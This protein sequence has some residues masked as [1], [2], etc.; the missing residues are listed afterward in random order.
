MYA[1][2]LNVA[3]P[4]RKLSIVEQSLPG[5][6]EPDEDE[7]ERRGLPDAWVY[8][9]DGWSLL[10]ESKIESKLGGNQLDRHYKTAIRRGFSDVTVLAI[11]VDRPARKHKNVLYKTWSEIYIWLKKRATNSQWASHAA[12]YLEV[13]ESRFSEDGYLKSGTLTRFSGIRFDAENP[14]SYREA[15]RVLRL[16]M[17]EL[18]KDKRLAKNLSIDLAAPGRAAITGSGRT[19][20]WDYLSLQLDD[21]DSKFTNYPHFT[22]A[23]GEQQVFVAVVVPNSINSAFRKELIGYGLDHYVETFQKVHKQLQKVIRKN[24]GSV[25]QLEVVQR[26][27]M[28]QRSS[29]EL[30]ARIAFDLN[31]AFGQK[32]DPVKQQ[33]LWLQTSFGAMSNKKGNTQLA[34]GII[35]PHRKCPALGSEKFVTTIA[36]TWL[37]C[38][39]LI[40][41]LMG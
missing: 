13:A 24:K 7:A 9:D 41:V 5:D 22:L 12:D 28:S 14:Y 2:E 18:R 36:D 37:A 6:S 34:V 31:T 35:F 1:S 11:D 10:I 26:H 16:A 29:P 21:A 40:K 38:R 32:G 23:I 19:A 30:D 25:S 8:D 33:P 39:P 20:V 15:K 27:Y 17:A 3:F 4:A